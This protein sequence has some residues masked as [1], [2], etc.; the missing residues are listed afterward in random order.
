MAKLKIALATTLLFILMFISST[1]WAADGLVSADTRILIDISG[2]MKKNDPNNLRRPAVR[3]LVGLLPENSRA[4]VWTF[5]KYV[6]MQVPLG[7]VDKR[8]KDR[9]RDGASKI[10]SPGQFTNIE[11]A[12]R[13]LDRDEWPYLWLHTEPPPDDDFP[14][15][16]FQVM[17]GR[18][19]YAMTLYKDG[20]EIHYLDRS[21][22]TEGD[23]VEIWE[24]DQGSDRG[25]K[26]LCNDISR[27]LEITR[28]FCDSGEL[29]PTVTWDV[30]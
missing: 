16:L 20:D 22:R 30:R 7:M 19:E 27:V 28:R 3:L 9:A 6:N 8:W 5:G 4:G 15:N 18:G 11:E 2:S 17:G 24:S 25:C 14:N 1:L 13:R 12:I 29:E 23:L 26:E 21:R 10:A